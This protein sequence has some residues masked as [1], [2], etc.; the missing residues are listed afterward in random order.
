MHI[1][2]EELLLWLD[3]E[4]PCRR[5]AQVLLRSPQLR[6]LESLHTR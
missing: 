3:A 1:S 5:L 6:E 4:L 2:D